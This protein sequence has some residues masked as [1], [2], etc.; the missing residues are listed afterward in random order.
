MRTLLVAMVLLPVWAAAESAAADG[1][2]F[3]FHM[4]TTGVHG[5]S[6]CKS[7]CGAVR[8][9]QDELLR[10][11]TDQD[12][13]SFEV[14][15]SGDDDQSVWTSM[16]TYLQI[17]DQVLLADNFKGPI[18]NLG[19]DEGA[20]FVDFSGTIASSCGTVAYRY[21]ERLGMTAQGLAS[22]FNIQFVGDCRCRTIGGE[23]LEDFEINLSG[24][25]NTFSSRDGIMLDP[26]I[27][28]G[29]RSCQADARC[30]CPTLADEGDAML[31]TSDETGQ[32][33]DGVQY[34]GPRVKVNVGAIPVQEIAREALDGLGNCQ[35]F[36]EREPCNEQS[37]ALAEVMLQQVVA[38]LPAEF[39]PEGR[40]FGAPREA[41]PPLLRQFFQYEWGNK[42]KT[43]SGEVQTDCGSGRFKLTLLFDTGNTLSAILD[44]VP[45]R[46]RCTQPDAL[47]AMG[48]Q[49]RMTFEQLV[50]PI[51]ED[52]LNISFVVQ[53]GACRIFGKC[54]DQAGLADEYP[55]TGFEFLWDTTPHCT[56]GG[57]GFTFGGSSGG[58]IT[59]IP[60]PLPIG[61][62]QTPQSG[63]P[64]GSLPPAP[65][66]GQDGEPGTPVPW[67]A[68]GGSFS[69]PCPYDDEGQCQGYALDF[70]VELDS[71]CEGNSCD[72]AFPGEEETP[73]DETQDDET[74]TASPEQTTPPTVPGYTP[75]NFKA[76]AAALAAGGTAA[77][78]QVAISFV[79]DEELGAEKEAD[80]GADEGAIKGLTNDEGEATLLLP[81][82]VAV[83]LPDEVQFE[84]HETTGTVLSFD[85]PAAAGAVVTPLL[86]PY[87]GELIV[88]QGMTFLPVSIPTPLLTGALLDAYEQ[89]AGAANT[90]EPDACIIQEPLANPYFT[91]EST[92]KQP[93]ADQWAIHRVGFTP[94]EHSA[95]Q[96]AKPESDKP[97]V[98]A[99]IDTGL[100]WNHREINW[101]YLWR[102]EDEIFG[103]GLDDDGNG[104]IDDTVGWD[105]WDNDRSPW[106]VAGHGTFVAGVMFADPDN[107]EGIAGIARH[108]RLM[109]LKAMNGFGHARA[110]S[111]ARAIMY[112][113]DNGASVI[114]LSLG[115]PTQSGLLKQAVDYAYAKDVV[116]VVASGNEAADASERAITRLPNVLTVAAS[117]FDDQRSVYSNFGPGIDVAAP[118][119]D[120]LSLRAR[121]TDILQAL[122][123]VDYISESAF[124][125]ADR[126]YYR[127]S[128]TSFAAPIVSGIAALVRANNPTLSAD[129][130]MRVLKQS[131]R[132]VETPGV[133]H[134]TGY[135]LVDAAAALRADAGYFIEPIIEAAA[136]VGM[137]GKPALEVV[138]TARADRL[139]GYTLA[140]GEGAQPLSWRQMV[141]ARQPVSSSRLGVIPASAF[142]GAKQWTI[143][144]TVQHKNGSSR[145]FRFILNLG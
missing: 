44:I 144:L 102:N 29:H 125:G 79:I 93:F 68:G 111:V 46:C 52:E 66:S 82:G 119:D 16:R 100:D 2:R 83:H 89:A 108:A 123:G 45:G 64:A 101:A 41:L 63:A 132:D 38:Q 120:V 92:W 32:I 40:S 33:L 17:A 129:E 112:A 50:V 13:P 135:G 48:Y 70:D 55:L 98:V 139:K 140:I 121:R 61:T 30:D 133:D 37:R 77:V 51:T 80:V 39:V 90:V 141:R 116:I 107:G 14:D 24:R 78:A 42:S 31:G 15:L 106:D 12:K 124:V 49:F 25:R 3:I 59:P 71:P 8:V 74:V 103:N 7:E 86:Q 57:G 22:D 11:F 95:W 131:A 97:V 58:G 69:L 96:Y 130:V 27:D 115:G 35:G 21:T 122:P 56:F 10:T 23:K 28:T 36:T 5:Y 137:D 127:A 128:G 62:P 143:R 9:L 87:V 84:V 113:A 99:V 88:V 34:S 91:S 109:P 65:G 4:P 105:F 76:T 47:A 118:G 6:L 19:D 72:Q 81:N 75:K 67:D 43:Y 85:S 54:C 145:E 126:R 94:D 53:P 60:S 142:A 134:F 104:Y 26:V 73:A 20:L 136:V 117:S 114:N 110:S 1:G 138:G 18:P